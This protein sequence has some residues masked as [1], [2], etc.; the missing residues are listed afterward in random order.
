VTT[1]SEP[2]YSGSLSAAYAHMSPFSI[3]NLSY[4]ASLSVSAAL[5]NTVIAGVPVASGSTQ[6][7]SLP[8]WVIQSEPQKVN[9]ARQ[10]ST[11]F[12]QSAIYRIGKINVSLTHTL[13]SSAGRKNAVLFGSISRGFDGLF[14][15]RF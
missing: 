4:N 7:Q 9:Q 1:T 15:P 2:S 13:V 5:S 3:P 12:Q 6:A 11:M 14:S 10:V 8:S